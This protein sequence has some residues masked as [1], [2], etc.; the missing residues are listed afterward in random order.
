[1]TEIVWRETAGKSG[2]FGAAGFGTLSLLLLPMLAC[3]LLVLLTVALTPSTDAL[4]AIPVRTWR[5]TIHPSLQAFA[6]SMSSDEEVD[7]TKGFE[8]LSYESGLQALQVYYKH[9]D[10]LVIPRSFEVPADKGQYIICWRFYLW[11]R[12][13]SRVVLKNV[14]SVCMHVNNRVSSGMG[15]C[16]ACSAYIQYGMVATAHSFK[17]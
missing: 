5:Q 4:I 15:R 8:S 6:L 9:H 1:M 17:Q 2:T 13:L 16:K 14:T 7:D 3:S 12:I 11:N 10:D